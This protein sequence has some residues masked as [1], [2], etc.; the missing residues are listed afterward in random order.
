MY[1]NKIVM[2]KLISYSPVA[3]GFRLVRLGSGKLPFCLRITLLANYG[4][5]A[6]KNEKRSPPAQD[7]TKTK[8]Q[9]INSSYYPWLGGLTT[10]TNGTLPTQPS[11]SPKVT[12]QSFRTSQYPAGSAEVHDISAST[13]LARRFLLVVVPLSLV[14]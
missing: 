13:G 7:D 2:T 1:K 8:S 10:H 4:N 6:A 9:K 5:E 14:P 12:N 11:P 3:L